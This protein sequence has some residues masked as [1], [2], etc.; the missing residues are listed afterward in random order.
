MVTVKGSNQ[1]LFAVTGALLPVNLPKLVQFSILDSAGLPI[2]FTKDFFVDLT[3]SSPF[4]RFYA[5]GNLLNSITQIK[6]PKSTSSGDFYYR[7]SFT[8]TGSISLSHTA[9]VTNSL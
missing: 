9:F 2:S 5:S 4:G 6:I 3:D 1:F 8:S 7:N